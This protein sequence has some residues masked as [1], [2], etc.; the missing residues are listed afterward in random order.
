[1]GRRTNLGTIQVNR[2]L[3]G[4]QLSRC[5]FCDYMVIIQELKQEFCTRLSCSL[6]SLFYL[7]FV[8]IKQITILLLRLNLNSAASSQPCPSRTGSQPSA[9]HTRVPLQ[10]DSQ[11]LYHPTSRAVTSLVDCQLIKLVDPTPHP[12]TNLVPSTE[13]RG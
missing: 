13:A 4:S 10:Q 5:S 6:G 3:Q 11:L 9:R 12:A 8:F 1:L 2:R 7:I